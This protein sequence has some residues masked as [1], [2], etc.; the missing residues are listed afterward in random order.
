MAVDV[1]VIFPQVLIP[2]SSVRTL[3]GVIPRS[4]DVIGTDFSSVDEVLINDVASPSVLI[5]SKTR[6]LAQVPDLLKRVTL[7]SVTVISGALTT[8][9]KSVLRFRLGP[10]TRKVTGVQRL[11][12][13]FLKI[14]FTTPGTDIFAPV[15]GA[16]ALKNIGLSFSSKDGSGIVADFTSYSA[17]MAEED[18]YLLAN[19][20][21]GTLTVSLNG[22]AT[23][24]RSV[25]VT[26]VDPALKAGALVGTGAVSSGQAVLSAVWSMNLASQ[27]N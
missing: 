15:I 11:M 22:T 3:E 2:L 6:L 21:I 17:G 12:Q 26:N 9:A 24:W 27:G 19:G 5:V 25:K 14:L 13:I 18:A 10:S 23:I 7:T 4:L 1:Q 8:N 16:A 20:A